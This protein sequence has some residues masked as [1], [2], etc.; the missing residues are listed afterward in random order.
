MADRLRRS[1]L[2]Q[3]FAVPSEEDIYNDEFSNPL[4]FI[5]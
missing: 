5:E 3:K 1:G 2:T 4:A